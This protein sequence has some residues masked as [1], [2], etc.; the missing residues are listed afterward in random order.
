MYL[1]R[2]TS[3]GSRALYVSGGKRLLGIFVESLLGFAPRSCPQS[4]R[5]ARRDA[6]KATIGFHGLPH[7]VAL[8]RR[9]T[10]QRTRCILGHIVA[11]HGGSL[12]KN[13]IRK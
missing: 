7:G 4:L 5:A 6:G 3:T 9:N 10:I 13:H 2:L 11:S 12:G 8:G 1:W